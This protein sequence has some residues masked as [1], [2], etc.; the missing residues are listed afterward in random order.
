MARG[1]RDHQMAETRHEQLHEQRL[2]EHAPAATAVMQAELALVHSSRLEVAVL[3]KACEMEATVQSDGHGRRCT[4]PGEGG[5]HGQGRARCCFCPNPQHVR[6]HSDRFGGN[7]AG[8]G[9]MS[10]IQ[11]YL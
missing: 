2:S 8:Y 9:S 6:V 7:E 1:T 10:L 11:A 3:E 4:A 5:H